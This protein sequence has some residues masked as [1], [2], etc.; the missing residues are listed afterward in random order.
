MRNL[1]DYMKWYDDRNKK[2]EKKRKKDTLCMSIRDD[3]GD[4]T[5]VARC[6]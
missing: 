1:C 2:H 5:Q 3:V 4:K 6:A